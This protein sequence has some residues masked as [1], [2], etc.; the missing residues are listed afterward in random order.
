MD[1]GWSVAEVAVLRL[2]DLGKSGWW[3]LL[4]LV[5]PVNLFLLTSLC[6]LPGESC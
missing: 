5:P 4:L 3:A 1:N 6:L 2:R